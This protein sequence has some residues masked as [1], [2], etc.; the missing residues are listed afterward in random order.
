MIWETKEA[1][2]RAG[3]H[4][5]GANK[6]AVT[7]EKKVGRPHRKSIAASSSDDEE[8]GGEISQGG[9]KQPHQRG[10]GEQLEE[11]PGSLLTQES[12]GR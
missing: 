5:E 1:H 7:M 4:E 6:E 12:N 3:W 8:E 11:K 2:R 10:M 9:A